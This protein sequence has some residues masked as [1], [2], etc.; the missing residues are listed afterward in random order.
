MKAC[1]KLEYFGIAL[2]LLTLPLVETPKQVAFWLALLGFAGAFFAGGAGRARLPVRFD[3]PVAT[4]AVAMWLV[5]LMSTAVNWPLAAGFKGLRDASAC[6]LLF[7]L[8][9]RRRSPA[10]VRR[11]PLFLVLGLFAAV[12]RGGLAWHTGS[13]PIWE[14]HS[15][16]VVT[17]S[18]IYIGMGIFVLIGVLLDSESGF[19]PPVKYGALTGAVGLF[20]VLLVMGSRGALLAFVAGIGGLLPLAGGNRTFR[21]ALGCLAVG[22]IVAAVL[23]MTQYRDSAAG[24]RIRHLK[25][26]I[27][28]RGIH[29]DRDIL[30]NDLNRIDHWRLGLR[31]VLEGGRPLLGVGPRNFSAVAVDGFSFDPPLSTYGTIWTKPGHAH[32]LLLTKAAEEGLLGVAALLVFLGAAARRL[33]RGRS[34]CGGLH[35]SRVA[36]VGALILPLI[37]GMFNSPFQNENAWLAMMLIGVGTRRRYGPAGP[38][39]LPCRPQ[40]DAAGMVSTCR[41]H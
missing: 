15:V 4:A 5:C 21:A 41:H 33:G 30:V 13:T 40:D 31:Q 26:N 22:G 12:V 34:P 36:A 7:W 20:A 10:A 19:T 35:W 14:L 9:H 38:L 28:R 29:L 1:R 11:L 24:E 18:A 27:S 16:G 37:A 32:N 3:D 2:L 23:V 25:A 6:V 39:S 17:R 8:L